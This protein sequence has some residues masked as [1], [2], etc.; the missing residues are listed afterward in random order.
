MALRFERSARAV[1]DIGVPPDEPLVIWVSTSGF[2]LELHDVKRRDG[3]RT[4]LAEF[5]SLSG[6]SGPV[7][8]SVIRGAQRHNL[9]IEC[10][11]GSSVTTA[12]VKAEGFEWR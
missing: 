2:K 9:K 12:Q 10:A 11:E 6:H 5:H 7:L 3:T 4:T 1:A 8:F